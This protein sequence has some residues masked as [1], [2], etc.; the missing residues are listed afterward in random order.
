[1]QINSPFSTVKEI[2]FKVS[3]PMPN[4]RALFL[5]RSLFVLLKSLWIELSVKYIGFLRY[6]VMKTFF[7]SNGSK[8]KNGVCV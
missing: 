6:G 2:S 1:M 3:L 4:G 8:G 7:F 5:G